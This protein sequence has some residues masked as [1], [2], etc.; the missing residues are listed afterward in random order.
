[1]A[2]L[3]DQV[4]VIDIEATCWQ[5]PPPAGEDNDVVEVG[6]ATLDLET[7]E[8]REKESLIV[9]PEHSRVSAFCTELT[10]LTQEQV[11]QGMPFAAA[12]RL[13]KTRF[14]S[15]HRAWAS[16][17]DYD[18]RQF[19]RQCAR[20]GVTYPFGATHLNVK[21]L[22][23]LAEGLRHEVGMPKA[24]DRL[25]LPLAGTHHRGDDDAWNIAAILAA[26]LRRLRGS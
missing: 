16:W 10:T 2:R 9:R 18:R 25:G 17:G 21:N 26:V 14:R 8:R 7:L 11:E 23:A 24:L 6:I 4:L 15:R 1:M 20:D 12:C 22:F 5:G 19:E 3:L 13:L